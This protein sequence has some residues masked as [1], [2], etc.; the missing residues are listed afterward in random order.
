M[1]ALGAAL[2]AVWFYRP[3]TSRS[4]STGQEGAGETSGGLSENTK[5]ILGRLNGPVQIRY[6]SLLDPAS[7]SEA[8][9]AY[10][11]RVEQLL[12]QYRQAAGGKIQVTRFRSQADSSANAEADGL[13]P[14]NLDKGDGCY[15]G[16]AV[17]ENGKRESLAQLAPEWE[18]ALESDL[19][20]TIERVNRAAGTRAPSPTRIS[21]SAVEEVKRALPKLDSI[22]V[23]EGTKVLRAASLAEYKAA[24]DGAQAQMRAAEERL[25]QAQAGGSEAEQQA[26]I[27]HLQQLQAEQTEK[28]KEIAARSQAQIEAFQQLKEAGR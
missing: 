27:K 17:V 19:S 8:T 24:I 11:D 13:T 5:A 4:Q 1:F 23:E 20:R 28:L 18:A 15:L 14:F 10:A 6:Y 22:S 3:S 16:L 9:R 2:S 12:A 21:A 26:A 7:V 25:T